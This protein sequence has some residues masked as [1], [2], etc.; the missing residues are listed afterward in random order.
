VL[1]AAE[2]LAAVGLVVALAAPLLMHDLTQV[3]DGVSGIITEFGG[4]Q[5]LI[6]IV[7]SCC[8]IALGAGS[9]AVGNAIRGVTLRDTLASAVIVIGRAFRMRSVIARDVHN[10]GKTHK[11]RDMQPRRTE[12]ELRPRCQIRPLRWCW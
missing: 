7:V 3:C 11:P 6:V 5:Y 9:D 10:S 8:S 2:V 4:W 1:S 12:Q